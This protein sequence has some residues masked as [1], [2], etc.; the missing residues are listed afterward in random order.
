MSRSCRATSAWVP[1]RSSLPLPVPGTAT[2][3]SRTTTGGRDAATAQARSKH[4]HVWEVRWR[5]DGRHRSRVFPLKRDAELFKMELW[6]ARRLGPLAEPLAADQTLAE[7]CIWWWRVHVKANL[8]SSTRRRYR[9]VL[10]RHLLPHLGDFRARDNAAGGGRVS[11]RSRGARVPNPTARKVLFVLQSIMR[12]A[13]LRG[14]IAHNPVKAIPKAAPREPH[15]PPAAAVRGRGHP[16]PP[17]PP[18]C[19]AGVATCL[20]RASAGRGARLAVARRE[21]PQRRD[22][23]VRL[24]RP[25]TCHEDEGDP[26]GGPAEATSAGSRRLPAGA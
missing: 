6:R 15:G 19:D 1:L 8:E 20:C 24:A 18:R 11:G 13:V 23:A 17:Q 26:W 21:R 7:F 2:S 4:G 16:Q 10:H 25:R 22:R 3:N 5:E 12:L 14:A 9:Q